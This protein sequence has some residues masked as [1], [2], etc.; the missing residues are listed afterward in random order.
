[1]GGS[2]D[3]VHT[4]HVALAETAL[5][6][7]QLDEVRWIPVGM[8][9]QKARQLAPAEDRLAMVKL[10]TAHEPRFVVDPIEVERNG[11][12]YT[13]DTFRT[14]RDHESAAS[15]WFLIIGQDQYANLPTWQGWEEL[16][17]G[18]TLAVA[19]RGNEQPQ[20]SPAMRGMAYRV[21]ELPLPALQLS[22]SAIRERVA[23]GEDPLSLAPDMVLPAVAR[24]I[25]NHQLYAAGRHPLNGHP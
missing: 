12:S 6:H 3:P 9:W 2:F 10:A 15:E 16:L 24:Y 18:L 5:R 17:Q 7:L 22:S 4:A 20:P 23:Q 21:A 1:M 25:A 13:I 8:A 19:C 14:L 11:P